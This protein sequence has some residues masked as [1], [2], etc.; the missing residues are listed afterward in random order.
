MAE[1]DMAIQ[2]LEEVPAIC[3]NSECT[4]AEEFELYDT[5]TVKTDDIGDYV[6]CRGCKQ[7]LYLD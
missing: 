7:K 2:R 4:H 6:K 3:Q 1:I 5:D